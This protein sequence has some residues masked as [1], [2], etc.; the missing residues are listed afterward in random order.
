MTKERRP[1]RRRLA[2]VLPDGRHAVAV[3]R[4]PAEA[5]IALCEECGAHFDNDE[6]ALTLA[7]GVA[8]HR[9]GTGH[10]RYVYYALVEVDAG[11][12]G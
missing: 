9:G 5:F 7:G 4:R 3:T 11:E 2:G 1:R 10:R 6:P 8:L 12:P